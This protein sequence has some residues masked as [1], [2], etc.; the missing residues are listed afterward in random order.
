M[1]L[2]DGNQEA[3]SF[4]ACGGSIELSRWASP[5]SRPNH[6]G[7][8]FVNRSGGLL[9]GR[10]PDGVEQ[11]A[12]G[13]GAAAADEGDCLRRVKQAGNG[14]GVGP[15]AHVGPADRPAWR[16][17]AALTGRAV[18]RERREQCAALQ[19]DDRRPQ[20]PALA[21]LRLL[22]APCPR[23][24]VDEDVPVSVDARRQV[25][26]QGTA[27]GHADQSD[28]GFAIRIDAVD[29]RLDRRH[30]PRV[31][32]GENR[33]CGTRRLP[34]GVVDREV[35]SDELIRDRYHGQSVRDKKGKKTWASRSVIEAGEWSITLDKLENSKRIFDKLKAIGGYAITHVGKLERLDGATFDATESERMFGALFRYLYPFGR[36]I[37]AGRGSLAP[38]PHLTRYREILSRA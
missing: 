4:F 31:I 8:P 11:A 14:D 10:S 26:R 13:A 33:G 23:L 15:A 37:L 34:G 17:S 19:R 24:H 7:H 25:R 21:G 1:L 2:E 5:F 38:G 32:E 12:A 9:L 35:L 20:P 3:G 18:D 27:C 30:D 6:V 29:F 16:P 36:T 22:P 28:D